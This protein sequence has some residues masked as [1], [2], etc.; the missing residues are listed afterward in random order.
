VQRQL[1][2][3]LVLDTAYVGNRALHLNLTRNANIPNRIT[4]VI[5]DPAFG[6][7]LFYDDSDASW[8]DAWQT[9]LIKS[10]RHGLNFAVNYNWAHNISY[11]DA[12]LQIETVPQDPDN[13]RAERGP[14]PFDIRQ[15]LRAN[16]IYMPEILKWTGWHNRLAKTSLD[17]WQ[18]TGILVA[19]S[20]ALANVIYG[21]SANSTDR[22]DLKA[23]V[24]QV[25]D[26]FSNTLVY[27]NKAAFT[28]VPLSSLSGME[29]HP[30]DLGRYALRAPGNCNLDFSMGRTF[31]L[32]ER[33]RLQL[34]GDAFNFAESH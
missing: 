23:G 21:S 14:T 20:G 1:P 10:F 27:L 5:P 25:F 34:R 26:N 33:Y 13:I 22:P 7:F 2:F 9:S 19:N 8:Y 17:G 29:V 12:D 18:F 24:A 6:S 28:L 4:G 3:G 32:T 15:S 16:F 30:G 31:M 11:G